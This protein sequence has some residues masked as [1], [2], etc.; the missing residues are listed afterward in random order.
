MFLH[1]L[2][3]EYLYKRYV[4]WCFEGFSMVFPLC[5]VLFLCFFGKNMWFGLRGFEDRCSFHLSG[6]R[7]GP[8]EGYPAPLFLSMFYF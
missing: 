4:S 7:L 8:S 3:G 2:V 6:I 5:F 1:G